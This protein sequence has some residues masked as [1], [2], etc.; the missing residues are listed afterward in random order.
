M[1]PDVLDP[2]MGGALGWPL[3]LYFHHV[4]PDLR[5]YTALTPEQF[6]RALGTVLD[7]FG[8]PVDPAEVGPGFRG[9]DRPAVLVTFDDGYRDNLEHAAPVLREFDVGV[10]LFC[11]T[12]E[13]DAAAA[14][15]ART[16][17]PP[18]RDFLT[19][20]E[21]QQFAREG[22]HVLSAHTHRHPDLTTV[23]AAEAAA[24]VERSLRVVADR[25]GAA[26]RTFA[27]PYGMVPARPPVPAD[28]LAFGTVR[29]R[30]VPWDERPHHVR[31][32][33]LPTGEDGCWKDLVD[34]WR[35][36]WFGSP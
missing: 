3:V 14:K 24:E 1:T 36:Q 29:S 12:G 31:R 32:T 20:S 28:V 16:A 23:A 35:R 9:P 6:R 13:L 27:Y 33:Y 15:P 7:G 8:P 30:P 2:A 11:S 21:A 34:G 18:R 4:H 25:T 22:G 5:H 10:L 26:P 17:R 19:W